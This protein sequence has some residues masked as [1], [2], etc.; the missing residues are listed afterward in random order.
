MEKPNV[1]VNF[2]YCYCGKDNYIGDIGKPYNSLSI[3]RYLLMLYAS[4]TMATIAK[5][6]YNDEQYFTLSFIY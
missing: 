4:H 5:N 1:R 3:M 2:N 6:L